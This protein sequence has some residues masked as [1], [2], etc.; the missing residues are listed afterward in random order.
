MPA[1]AL[2]LNNVAFLAR[3]AASFI[4]PLDN[5]ATNLMAM[6]S[7]A[8]RLLTSYTGSLIRV[9][10][11]S[12]S[13]EQ[14]IGYVANGGLD[15]AS[16]LTFV[17]GGN[18]FITK[19]YDQSGLGRNLLQATASAQQSIVSAGVVI[20]LGGLP[21][22]KTTSGAQGYQTAAFTTYTGVVMS[23]FVRA[24]MT[25]SQAYDR[26]LSVA[27]GGT[28]F[29]SESVSMLVARGLN[30]LALETYR[31]N[32]TV[33]AAA[34]ASYDSQFVASTIYN[35][36]TGVINTGTA[37]SSV[38]T[39]AAFSINR[40]YAAGAYASSNYVNGINNKWAE[41]VIYSADQTANR[42]AIVAALTP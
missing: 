18:G 13:T 19:V 8:R 14:D 16:L 24:T 7:V 25:N 6:W 39:T 33:A 22:M 34:L 41:A 27:D 36:T 15:T 21:T 10:R 4:G 28:D 32:F 9:R 31:G 5:Y 12:D 42:A 30:T 11:S 40:V 20:T 1:H 38:A 2:S 26:V 35:G 17:G 37:S 23:A 29:A 3:G